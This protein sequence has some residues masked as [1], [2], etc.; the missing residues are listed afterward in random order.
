MDKCQSTF[1]DQMKA[2]TDLIG[3]TQSIHDNGISGKAL[4]GSLRADIQGIAAKQTAINKRLGIL[5]Q[6][7]EN[8][9][10]LTRLSLAQKTQVTPPRKRSRTLFCKPNPKCPSFPHTSN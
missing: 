3:I 5:E 9:K 7:R 6:Y 10:F 8:A 2:I 4:M 1:K